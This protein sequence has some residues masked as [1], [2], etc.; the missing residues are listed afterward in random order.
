MGKRLTDIQ[1]KNIVAD[2]I[3]CQNYS[4]VARKHGISDNA[5]RNIVKN[6]PETSE[7]FEQKQIE[8]TEDTLTYMQ[9]QHETKKRIA[10]KLLK[11]IES[12]AESVDMFTN[13]KDLTTAY[14]II[15]DKELKFAEIKAAQGNADGNKWQGLPA[16]ALGRAYADINRDIDA[17][18]YTYYDFKGGRGSLKSSYCALKLIDRI[19]TY[20]NQCALAVRQVKDTLKDSVYSQIVWAIDELNL[21]DDFHCTKSPMEIRRKSTGQMIYFRGADDPMKIKS[22]RPPKD[23][24]IGVVWIEE[25]DQLHGEEALRSILQ[26]AMRGGEN[27]IVFR[28]YNT[29]I[30]QAHF[31][32]KEALQVNP[33]RVVHHSYYHEA[34][35]EWLGQPF[36]DMAEHIK[37]IN[38]RA[39]RH[40]YLGEAVGTGG[41]V[42]ENVTTRAIT[43]EEINSFG[44]FYYGLDFGWYP[45]PLHFAEM[46]YNPNQRTL[47]IFGELRLFKTSNEAVADMLLERLPHRPWITADSAEPKSIADLRA[48]GLNVLSAHKGPGSVD[49][50][51][52]WLQSLT[53]I[54]IDPERCPHT[55]EEFLGYEYERTKDGD[56]ISAYPD[57]NNHAIDSVRYAMC[58]VWR[59]GGE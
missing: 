10:E 5:V 46:S 48:H 19:M 31:V 40:E 24:Y 27:T 59:R 35:K 29:P 11:A 21:T 44:S 43:D 16:R 56:I 12:K 2:Y 15:I 55:A 13:V 1:R 20:E 3:A 58:D 4:E 30:S 51:M 47:Y 26:S 14:G 53:E 28:S 33:R 39:Y 42:F 7:K 36:F 9:Q 57:I 37:E 23:M 50:S 6:Q 49:Y 25:Y 52:K 34:P 17:D 45:D 38:E 32:N 18:R 54:V 41:N 8:N 22:L